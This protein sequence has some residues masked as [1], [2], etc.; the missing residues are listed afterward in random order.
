MV[1]FIIDK[2]FI[3]DNSFYSDNNIIPINANVNFKPLE[4]YRNSSHIF[5]D[6][7]CKNDYNNL[8]NNISTPKP[9]SNKKYNIGHYYIPSEPKGPVI[10]YEYKPYFIDTINKI[11]KQYTIKHIHISSESVLPINIIY[12][13]KVNSDVF[14]LEFLL[15]DFGCLNNKTI[16]KYIPKKNIVF[17]ISEYYTIK[18]ENSDSYT[19]FCIVCEFVTN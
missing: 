17:D 5:R 9:I 19:N 16:H 15:V 7:N 3:P 2:F 12:T 14:E 1:Y 8:L 13:V 11:E 6:V 18:L 10:K 4:Y